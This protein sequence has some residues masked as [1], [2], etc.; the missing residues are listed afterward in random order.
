MKKT[1]LWAALAAALLFA[2]S[3]ASTPPVQPTPEPEPQVQVEPQK[4]AVPAPEAELAKAKELKQRADTYGL[5]DYA[6]EEYA[7][8]SKDLAAG[9]ASYGKDNAASKQSLDKAIAGFTS[10][11]NKG[12][13]ALVERIQSESTASK[14]AADDA[15]APVAVKDEYAAALAVYNGA[16][17]AKKAG[18]LEKAGNDFAQARDMFDAVAKTALAKREKALQALQQ[19]DQVLAESEAKASEAAQQL[20]SEGIPA[21]GSGQ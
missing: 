15:K 21:T 5:A 8:A 3:C 14:K 4:P 19:T 16:L 11:I 13:A 7:A 9:E 2:A 18:N 20:T 17:A 1:L 12:G 6:P 10:V